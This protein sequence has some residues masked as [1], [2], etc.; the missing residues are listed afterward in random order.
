M[1]VSYTHLLPGQVR[2]YEKRADDLY[3]KLVDSRE[4]FLE[5]AGDLSGD[6][7]VG[8]EEEISQYEA[9][10]AQDGQRRREVACL[11]YTSLVFSL[12]KCICHLCAQQIPE[13]L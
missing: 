7:R 2:S 8:L 5:E 10:A 9:Y 1:A 3:E 4:K 13:I 6:V 12:F 11:L